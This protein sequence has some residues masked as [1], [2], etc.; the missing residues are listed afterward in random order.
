MR[1]LVDAEKRASAWGVV[2]TRLSLLLASTGLC[3][4]A[5][6]SPASAACVSDCWTGATSADWFVSTNWTTGTPTGATNVVIDQGS[7]NANPS[8]GINGTRNAAASAAVEIADSAGTTGFVTLS[9]TNAHPASWTIGGTLVLGEGGNGTINVSNGATLINTAGQTQIGGIPGAT[10]TLTIDGVGSLWNEQANSTPISVG[11]GGTGFLT[12]TNGAVVETTGIVGNV[13]IGFGSGSTGTVTVGSA[14]S[15]HLANPSTLTNIGGGNPGIL[16]VG[17]GGNGSL[18]INS[19]G[20][21]TGFFGATL[22]NQSGSQGTVTVNGGLLDVT[23]GLPGNLIVGGSGLGTLTIENGGTVTSSFGGIAEQSGSAGSSATV[24]GVGSTW[25]VAAGLN[26]GDAGTGS[27]SILAG[28][29]VNIASGGQ[30]NVGGDFGTNGTGTVIVDNATLRGNGSFFFVG[31]L[32]NPGSMLTVQNGGLVVSDGGFV[33]SGLF[34][35]SATGV[36]TVT[37]AGSLWDAT[38]NSAGLVNASSDMTINNQL[39]M[40]GLIIQQGGQVVDGIGLVG[41]QA[42]NDTLNTVVVDGA[43]SKW[44]NLTELAVGYFQLGFG[45]GSSAGAVNIT[46]GG[47]VTAPAVLIGTLPDGGGGNIDRIAVSGAGSSLQASGTL[48]VAEFGTGALTISGGATVSD[49]HGL[50]AYSSA[51]P[52][53]LALN[54]FAVLD[55]NN[56]GANS[57]GIV[58][59]TGAGSTWNNAT[60]LTVGDNTSTDSHYS[61]IGGGTATA[62]L[63]VSDG[64]NVIVNGGTGTINVAVNNGATGT[65]NIGAAKGDAAAAPGTI[66][67]A[68]ILF[69]NGTGSIVFNHTSANYSFGASIQGPG[70]VDVEGGTTVL[71]ANST[72]SGATTVNGGTLQVD[73]SIANSNV[74]VNAGGTLG[75]IGIVGNTAINGGTLAPGSVSGSAFGPLTVQGN[76]SFTAASTYMIQVSPAG[77]TNV[78]GTATLGG[79]T[80]AANFMTSSFVQKQYVIVNATG[81]VSGTFGSLV[82]TNLPSNI[83]ASLGYDAHDAFLNLTM[84]PAAGLNGN[85][86]SVANALTNAFNAGGLPLVFFGLSPAAL[87]QASGEVATGSQQTTFD[88][89]NLFL[90]VLTDPFVAGRGDGANGAAG[91]TPFTDENDGASAYAADGKPRSKSERDAYAAIYRKAPLM[92]DSFA[93]RWSVWAAGF[94]G[95]QTTDGNAALGSNTATSRIAGTAVGADYRFSPSTLAGFALAGGGTNFSIAGGLGSGRSDLFQAGAFIRHTVGPAYIS[96]AL[97]YGWQDITTDRIVTIAGIDRLRA[98]FNANAV[99]GRIE[100]GNRF[101]T[102]SMGGIGITPYAAAQFTT[103]DLPAYAEQVLS[104]ASTFALAYGSRS[105]TDT[106]SELG[107][108]TD[109]SYAMQNAIL[110]LRGR[111]AWAHDFDP[112]RNIA[113]TFQALPGASFVV[114]GAA[115]AHDAALTTAS[116]EMKW[117]NGWSAAATFEG[118]FSNVTASYAGKGVVRYTW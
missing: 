45:P 78:T 110:T 99:S 34:A 66:S 38:R 86:Q 116:A 54:G 7:P 26:V 55:T 31:A 42:A 103:F 40:T 24:T 89:M 50:I 114:N 84:N 76:L 16:L 65:I 48:L 83:S 25:N 22:G 81:G 32:G 14:T 118:E 12:I 49:N 60:S 51:T 8:I 117:A 37:G 90:G 92:A 98:E 77:R 13:S 18:T 9:T 93:Q 74:T 101:V 43:G 46:N 23:T 100:G 58:T 115:Q 11:R 107:V 104:S 62:T 109:K 106:R 27:L 3:V 6:P 30:L 72:Y 111:L 82:A 35:N 57:V 67:A 1:A 71:T 10:G 44:T 4:L 33:G 53:S 5:I 79:A 91:A 64:G 52:G 97:A 85:Q 41:N 68:E 69:G 105:V 17:D 2:S 112:D 95:S 87:T 70:T 63:T 75:G 61:G 21:V 56:V 59:V 94:G 29:T 39:S 19:D 88:A 47:Q 102:P 15:P 73:G 80:V 96:G 20:A 113:A 108:R 28:G 36:V